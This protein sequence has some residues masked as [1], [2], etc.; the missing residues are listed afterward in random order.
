MG[1]EALQQMILQRPQLLG[2]GIGQARDEAQERRLFEMQRSGQLV[3]GILQAIGL[4]LEQQRYGEQMAEGQRQFN[5]V[6]GLDQPAPTGNYRGMPVPL[7]SSPKGYRAQE[8]ERVAEAHGWNRAVQGSPEVQEAA[9]TARLLETLGMDLR[10]Q[11]AQQDLAFGAATMAPRVALAQ[12]QAEGA[13]IQNEA[14]RKGMEQEGQMFPY[15]L[16]G[17]RQSLQ[18]GAQGL[19][20]GALEMEGEKQRQQ[21]AKEQQDWLKR[22]QSATTTEER[23]AIIGENPELYF[24]SREAEKERSFRGS[25][26]GAAKP[27]EAGP[28]F[29]RK[30]LRERSK[31]VEQKA[32]GGTDAF[33]NPLSEPEVAVARRAYDAYQIAQQVAD[34]DKFP[35]VAGE[36]DEAYLN[37]LIGAIARSISGEDPNTIFSTTPA[38]GNPGSNAAGEDFTTPPR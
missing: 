4:A 29:V 21:A 20:R 25:I 37:R 31:A 24:Q 7:G 10:N 14:A 3:E 19:E 27:G 35:R 38:I 32:L 36:S 28:D 11:G 8:A 15:R 12:R 16:Q 17:A 22:F 13:G 1:M 6:E 18:Q 23:D 34:T 33:G 26:A 2:Y 30:E 5:V 9:R